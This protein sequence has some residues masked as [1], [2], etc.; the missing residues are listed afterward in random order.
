[1]KKL[2]IGNLSSDSTENDLRTVFAK[3]ASVASVAV[4]TDKFSGESRGFAFVE[5]GDEEAAAAIR[6]L[7]GSSLKGKNLKVNEARPRATESGGGRSGRN[8]RY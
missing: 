3:Y 2:Y 8:S 7:D 5:M 1:M 4:V 6:D